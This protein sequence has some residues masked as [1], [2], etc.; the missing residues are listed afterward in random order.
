MAQSWP[1]GV[2][3]LIPVYNHQDAVGRVVA[4]LRALGAVVLVVDDGSSDDSGARAAAAG[5]VVHRLHR[6]SG[7]G[8]ALRTGLRLA[9]DQGYHQAV[10]VDA[11]GQH[12][13]AAAATLAQAARSTTTILVG[14]R[15]MALA[16]RV[17]RF[18]R[19]WSNLWVYLCCGAWVGD[20]QSGLRAYPVELST[21]LPVRAGHYAWEVE[22]LVRAVW[23]GMAVVS[24]PVPVIY[25]PDRV[26]HFHAARDN[27][28]MSWA[29][30]LLSI[31]RF[32]PWHARLVPRQPSRLRELF[33]GNLDPRKTA[34]ACALGAAMG[35][36]PL[37]GLQMAAAAWLAWR[38]RLNLTVTLLVSNH[39][40]GPMLALWYAAA[41][42]LG[43]RILSH[44]GL[45]AAFLQLHRQLQHAHGWHQVLIPLRT[46]L[47]AWLLG[48]GILMAVVAPVA[49]LIGYLVARRL[50]RRSAGGP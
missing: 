31:R 10:S 33:T 29:F 5:A 15:D 4:E 21:R 1:D 23:A 24:L 30:F 17:S 7:K 38:L 14:R 18:G 26:S 50:V 46:C 11:D 36:A 34:Q 42:A 41:T 25:P 20:S 35:I 8:E 37:P 39:S 47:G 43:L 19:W 48:C 44:Q 6:N 16:P 3:A 9:H 27:A 22:V 49:G 13:T 2:V 32:W 40:F 12:P 28:R 45:T